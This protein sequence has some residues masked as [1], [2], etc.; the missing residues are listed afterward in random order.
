MS[1]GDTLTWN[2]WLARLEGLDSLSIRR[3]IKPKDFGDVITCQIH[4]FV[5]ASEAAY[6][7]VSYIRITNEAGAIHCSFLKGKSHLTP[8]KAVTIPRLELM[9]AV[10]GVR[11]SAVVADAVRAQLERWSVEVQEF[12]W[13]DSTTVL[14]YISNRKTRF[15]TFVANRLAVIHDGSLPSQW[16]HVPSSKNPTDDVSRGL[17]SDR[18]LAGPE[19]FWMPGEHWPEMPRALQVTAE[20]PEVKAMACA[21]K[22]V[23][24]PDQPHSQNP[25]LKLAEHYS[26]RHKLL[27]AIAWILKVKKSLKDRCRGIPI[28]RRPAMLNSDDIREAEG[29]V[30]GSLQEHTFPKEAAA[31]KARKEV[32]SGSK[33]SK[34]SPFIEDG[35]IKVG[36][37]LKDAE[38][39]YESQHPNSQRGKICG[40]CH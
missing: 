40:H 18:W 3:C 15:H 24:P 27:R 26:S 21:M 35:I 28:Q 23:N 25:L 17:Q 6:G 2:D 32:H 39:G 19:F 33:L 36:G 16:N 37:R 38:M 10:T 31:L 34:L 12:F 20:D 22:T 1:E 13:T 9:A 4:I 11:L 8:L 14:R 5:D 30:V 29:T 7:A